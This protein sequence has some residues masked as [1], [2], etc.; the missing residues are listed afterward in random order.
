MKKVVITFFSFILAVL[1]FC[2]QTKAAEIKDETMMEVPVKILWGDYGNYLKERPEQ[3]EFRIMD[4]YGIESKSEV[5]TID[6][7]DCTFKKINDKNT[8]CYTTIKLPKR[9]ITTGKYTDYTITSVGNGKLKT[10]NVAEFSGGASGENPESASFFM[11]LYTNLSET[12]TYTINWDDDHDRDGYRPEKMT[13]TMKD[14]KG[15]EEL[16]DIFKPKG[17]EKDAVWTITN[18]MPRFLYDDKMIPIWDTPLEYTGHFYQWNG[19]EVTMD[20]ESEIIINETEVTINLKHE[21]EKLDY[22]IPVK[23]TWEDN[24]NEEGVRPELLNITA[25][26]NDNT[27]AEAQIK[28]EENWEYSF[29]DLYKYDGRYSSAV[30]AKYTILVADVERYDFEVL[31]NQE[32]GFEIIATLKEKVEEDNQEIIDE[33]NESDDNTK[34]KTESKIEDNFIQ[35]DEA[36]EENNIKTDNSEEE[37]KPPKTGNLTYRKALNIYN[38]LMLAI[39]VMIIVVAI[40]VHNKKEK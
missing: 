40:V 3:V 2:G 6:L 15:K 34:A 8:A 10:Y 1:F 38:Y 13:L 22:E 21:P 4:M 23:I 18:V 39:F 12:Y 5:I 17:H 11:L 7:K 24:N 27:T 35:E 33:E 14:N 25:Y 28:S 36:K 20:Y 31:G 26:A 30:K 32:N 16:V 19:G 9:D 29:K 37:I